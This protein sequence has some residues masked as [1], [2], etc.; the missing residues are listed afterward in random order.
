MIRPGR[1]Q[2]LWDMGLGM[3][4]IG[5]KGDGLF[6]EGNRGWDCSSRIDYIS[7]SQW[8]RVLSGRAVMG[9]F[10]PGLLSRAFF[11]LVVRWETGRLSF[12]LSY[13]HGTTD[14]WS[15]EKRSLAQ[16]RI[17]EWSFSESRL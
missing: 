17:D 11:R 9:Y 7:A 3:W 13:C 1:G 10:A 5:K 14:V 16:A 2:G 4:H 15:S 6:W 8:P 12:R